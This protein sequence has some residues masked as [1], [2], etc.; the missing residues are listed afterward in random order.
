MSYQPTL[1]RY[2]RN[3]AWALCLPLIA[4]F[5]LAATIASALDHWRGKGASWKNR[6]YP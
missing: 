3:P 1:R 6:A 2:Q 4:L 5:Y